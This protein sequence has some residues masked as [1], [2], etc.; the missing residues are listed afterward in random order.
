MAFKPC[1]TAWTV[2]NRVQAHPATDAWMMGDRFGE[3]VVIGS[4]LVH[5][6]MDRSG[7][8]LKFRPENLIG[9]WQ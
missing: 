8:L 3:I 2:G 1:T 5:V 4:K 9:I 7:R 6:R